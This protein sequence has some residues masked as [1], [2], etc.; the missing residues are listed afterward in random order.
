MCLYKGMS[1]NILVFND[2]N[3]FEKKDVNFFF[4]WCL[5]KAN[6]VLQFLWS[7]KGIYENKRELLLVLQI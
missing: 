4:I 5:L 6:E 3:H 1:A 2:D 7:E